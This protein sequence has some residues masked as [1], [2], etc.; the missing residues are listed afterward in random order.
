MVEWYCDGAGWNGKYSAYCIVNKETGDYEL[1]PLPLEKTNNEME[2]AA[3][4]AAMQK[5]MQGDIILTDSQLVCNQV[6][7]K[8]KVKKPHLLP[9]CITARSL[10]NE[11]KLQIIWCSRKE[12]LA[13][14]LLEGLKS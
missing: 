4:I 10:L 13:G 12:N 7:G 5:A 8:W 3:V 14:H 1:N 9:L 2:Y 6:R 11:K